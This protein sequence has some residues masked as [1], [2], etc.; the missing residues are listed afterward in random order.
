MAK[1][2]VLRLIS[3][4][5]A[6]S[7]CGSPT[8]PSAAGRLT[9]RLLDDS[10]GQPITGQQFGIAVTATGPARATIASS[11]AIAEFAELPAGTYRMTTDVAFGYYQVDF[12]SL[13][14]GEAAR[15]LDL[16]LKPIDDLGLSEVFVDGQGSIPKGGT[17]EMSPPG[18]TIRF[19]GGYK[20]VNYA[21]PA[22]VVHFVEYQ[23]SPENISLS[24]QERSQ[25]QLSP[26]EWEARHV[27]LSPA[28]HSFDRI[29]NCEIRVNALFLDMM[30]PQGRAGAGT[31]LMLKTQSWPLVFRLRG[32]YC[33]R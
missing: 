22:N 19:R 10:T 28:A 23:T 30:D 15:S 20:I 13:T 7:A 18:V 16:R 5:L 12:I 21:F 27:N 3:L 11:N 26:G 17:I 25:T 24:F 2:R 1:V 32:A 31:I 4:L 33:A 9:V 29:V 6:M 8:S 14:L